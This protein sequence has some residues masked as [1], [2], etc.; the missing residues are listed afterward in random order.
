MREPT[1]DEQASLALTGVVSQTYTV[2]S[3]MYDG[4]AAHANILCAALATLERSEFDRGHNAPCLICGEP[5]S[6][7]AGNPSRLGNDGWSHT[8]CLN[9]ALKRVELLEEVAE[10]ARRWG[11]TIPAI[12]NAITA[13]AAADARPR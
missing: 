7:L 13:L 10:A 5:C 2:G 3:A 6:V 8:G 9:N 4:A 11:Y 1:I 12:K